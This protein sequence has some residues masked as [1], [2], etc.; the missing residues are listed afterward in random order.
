MMSGKSLLALVA[1]TLL[2]V[3]PAAAEKPG[4]MYKIGFLTIGASNGPVALAARQAI[5]DALAKHNYAVGANLSIQSRFAEGTPEKLPMLTEELVGD[6]VDVII[7]HGD[8]A[9][10]A[11]KD[12][13]EKIPIVAFSVGDPVGTGLV[14]SLK[15][16]GGHLTG[17]ADLSQELSAKRLELLEQAVPGLK[18]VAMLW[19]A[20]DPAMTARY[21][22]AAEATVKLGIHVQALGVREP[23]DFEAAFASMTR[24]KPDGITM[25]T[26]VLTV[27]NRKRVFEFAAVHRIPAMY[28]HPTLVRDGGLMAYGPDAAET[29]NLVAGLIDRILSGSKPADLPFEQPTHFTFAINLKTAKALELAIPHGMLLRADEVIE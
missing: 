7:A 22:I 14:A 23:D 28:E 17:V 18:R 29:A 15:R 10:N 3:S 12:G 8:L 5:I 20:N 24:E 19:N 26:D 1:L 13:S 27:L 2:A 9:A 11:A 25:V 6:R 16:P 4:T 21:R